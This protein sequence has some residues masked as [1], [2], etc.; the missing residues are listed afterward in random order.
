MVQMRLNF[1]Q[2]MGMEELPRPL[3]PDEFPRTLRNDI[4]NLIY[5]DFINGISFFK[6]A[7]IK[8][9][10][11]SFYKQ[12]LN[13]F[14]YLT[15]NHR[16]VYLYEKGNMYDI[17][18]D[19]DYLISCSW[20]EA[21][22]D[23]TENLRNQLKQIFDNHQFA[24]TIFYEGKDSQI[25]LR[26]SEH[27][28]ESI[29]NAYKNLKEQQFLGGVEHLTKA[30]KFVNE[31]RYNDSIHESISAVE[32][33]CRKLLNRENETLASALNLLDKKGLQIH[34]SLKEGLKKIYGYTSDENG[35]RHSLFDGKNDLALE[36]AQ[37]M[38]GSCASFISYLINKSNN[39]K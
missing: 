13:K 14:N 7:T 17:L 2:R 36:D 24:Y 15:E 1:K 25:A 9:R 4:L 8:M 32:C 12:P 39:L 27:E 34:T 37:F 33:V 22:L 30:T 31:G 10:Y 19:L 21:S 29:E 23:F 26:S 35:I 18:H 11:V 20:D 5:Q 3:K 6:D 28:I 16:M 38:I